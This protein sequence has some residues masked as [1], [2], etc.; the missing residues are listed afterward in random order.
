M[1][2]RSCLSI[3]AVALLAVLAGCGGASDSDGSGDSGGDATTQSAAD[4]P[5]GAVALV[6]HVPVIQGTVTLAELRRAIAQ[7]AAQQQL[8]SAPQPGD[9]KYAQTEEAALGEILDAIWIEGEG[10]ELSLAVS[11]RRID[12]ELDQIK[13]KNFKTQAAYEEFLAQSDLTEAET[14]ARVKQQ[15]LSQEIQTLVQSKGRGAKDTERK[16]T[17]YVKA[18]QNKWRSRT[19]CGEEFVTD[20]CSNGPQEG[21]RP[22]P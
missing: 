16:F 3:A 11:E 2:I 13:Q 5:P 4:L 6:S 20:S 7:Q 1:P 19:V 9:P 8:P 15:L 18:F 17:A 14:R 21:S 22:T 10:E 12:A